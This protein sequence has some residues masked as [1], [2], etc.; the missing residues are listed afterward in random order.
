MNIN[1]ELK[2]A[3]KDHWQLNINGVTMG[4]WERSQLRHLIEVIDNTIS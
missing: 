2:P 1:T 3:D 4:I